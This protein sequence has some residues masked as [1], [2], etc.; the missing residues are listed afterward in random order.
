MDEPSWMPESKSGERLASVFSQLATTGDRQDEEMGGNGDIAKHT[1]N[2]RAEQRPRDHAQRSSLP[3]F[4]RHGAPASLGASW[5]VEAAVAA[6]A[7][8]HRHLGTGGSPEIDLLGSWCPP[9]D[10][11][12][13]TNDDG[14]ID[15]LPWDVG[16][17]SLAFGSGSLLG[18]SR[19][20]A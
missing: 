14:D 7:V 10:H 9:K 19:D 17:S 6:A 11:L 15:A 8:A 3:S 20:G 4:L 12:V 18:A 13:W 1:T 5:E 16:R 2:K